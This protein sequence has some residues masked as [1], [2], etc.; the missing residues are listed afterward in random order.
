MFFLQVYTD[1][2]L[3][4]SS[5]YLIYFI[6][7]TY[8]YTFCFNYCIKEK[9]KMKIGVKVGDLMTRDLITV[10]S[11]ANLVDCS[12]KM[13]ERN[14][15]LLI[16]KEKSRLVGML[17][18]KEIIW[19]LTKKNNL[20]RVRAGDVMLRKLTTIKPS[21][22]VYDALLRMKKHNVRWLPITIRKNVIGLITINDIL[23]VEPALFEIALGNF[24]VK[25]MEDKMRRREKSLSGE[26]AWTAEG[27]CAECGAF[28]LLYRVN[29]G[30]LCENCFEGMDE[31]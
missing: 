5:I 27:E 19:A 18:E 9:A 22:D 13:S 21:R 24:K 11:D 28:G 7:P 4:V 2:S 10:D 31:E 25:E 6:W 26:M 16:V 30:H 1:L 12:R 3:G 15:G 20:S 17:T 29:Q 23:K 8:L 14:V